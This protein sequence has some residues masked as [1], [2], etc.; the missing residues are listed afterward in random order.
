[1]AV[2]PI[3]GTPAWVENCAIASTSAEPHDTTLPSANDFPW[4]NLKWTTKEYLWL[5]KQWLAI[6]ITHSWRTLTIWHKKLEQKSYLS[7]GSSNC[8][9]TMVSASSRNIWTREKKLSDNFR[10]RRTTN[11]PVWNAPQQHNNNQ[12]L[13]SIRI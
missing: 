7:H 13:P 5:G 6:K 12:S 9:R 11:A 1:M 2:L 4:V 8:K 10:I 3:L